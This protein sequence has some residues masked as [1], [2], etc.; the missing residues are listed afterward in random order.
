MLKKKKATF[1]INW[2][3]NRENKQNKKGKEFKKMGYNQK[4]R[5]K[6]KKIMLKQIFKIVNTKKPI[7]SMILNQNEYYYYK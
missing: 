5:K 1:Q 7:F 6:Y 2:S 3:R 4:N